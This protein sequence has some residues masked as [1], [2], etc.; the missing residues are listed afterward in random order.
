[1]IYSS[2]DTTKEAFDSSGSAQDKDIEEISILI[3]KGNIKEIED[4]IKKDTTLEN[5]TKKI[6]TSSEVLHP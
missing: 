5:V 1:M 2:V 3:S 4:L 6:N